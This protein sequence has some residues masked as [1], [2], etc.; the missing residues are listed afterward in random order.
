MN[1]RILLVDD[2]IN[3]LQ[4]YQRSFRHEFGRLEVA[5]GGAQALDS[6]ARSGPYAVVVSDMRM[7]AMDG[8]AFLARAR[9]LAPRT[10][11]MMLTGYA[12]LDLAI[13]AVR[14]GS[15]FRILTKPCSSELLAEA[16]RA[17]LE[18]YRLVMAEV[19]LLEKT[20]SGSINLLT[21]LLSLLDTESFRRTESVRTASRA[22][23]KALGKSPSWELDLAATLCPIGNVTLPPHVL[24]KVRGG[25]PL[26][27]EEAALMDRVPEIGARL[28]GNIPRLEGVAQMVLHQA[29]RFDGTGPPAGDVAEQRIP[30]GARV[31][32]VVDD[33][34]GL[35]EQGLSRGVALTRMAVRRGWYD[36]QVLS[37]AVACFRHPVTEPLAGRVASLEIP[38]RQLRSGHVL[39]A[40]LL[41]PDGRMLLSAGIRL[42]DAHM[43]RVRH[44]VAVV[45]VREPVYVVPPPEAA[46]SG[47]GSTRRGRGTPGSHGQA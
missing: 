39:A 26:T 36:P 35:E 19:E 24:A 44:F 20:L 42:T 47:G 46:E 12:D 33:M 13:R 18:H 32:K 8:L 28:L 23:W 17:G 41:S 27:P 5:A 15:I 29:K 31:L 37:A 14:E 16:L 1:D 3:V 6:M 34:L 2:D 45:G 11:R 30:L 9:E 21:D 22:A 4:S 38:V 43:E 40:H 7:P 10:V 25:Q